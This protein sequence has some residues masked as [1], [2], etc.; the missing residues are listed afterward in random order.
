MMQTNVLYYGHYNARAAFERAAKC[1]RITHLIVAAGHYLDMPPTDPRLLATVKI[2]MGSGKPWILCRPLWPVNDLAGHKESDLWSYAYYKLQVTMIRQDAES[3]GC[4]TA[5]D[6]EP[7]R[8]PVAAYFRPSGD[9][10][11][12]EKVLTTIQQSL[13]KLAVFALRTPVDFILP[14]GA[15]RGHIYT[16]LARLAKARICEQTYCDTEATGGPIDYPYEV[17]GIKMGCKDGYTARRLFTE[18]V[19]RLGQPQDV[20]IFPSYG[21][22][23][24]VMDELEALR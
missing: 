7:Y 6:A 16:T 11:T 14:A 9:G 19:L 13:L 12:T 21:N 15:P 5:F 1:K 10:T 18:R 22:E 17:T 2:A 3:F 23:D 24:A 8:S 20:M 4:A